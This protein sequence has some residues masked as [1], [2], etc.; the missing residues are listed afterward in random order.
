MVDYEEKHIFWRL[1]KLLRERIAM[2]YTINH[3]N[4]DWLQA[5][6]TSS[7]QLTKS[8][9]YNSV[10]IPIE[11]A[12]NSIISVFMRIHR[13]F[14]SEKTAWVSLSREVI[15]LRYLIFGDRYLEGDETE[16]TARP[17]VWLLLIALGPI[18]SSVTE[19]QLYILVACSFSLKFFDGTAN[20]PSL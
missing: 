11:K 1:L 17:W 16:G 2:S 8:Y 19:Q 18:A 20:I 5:G 12:A 15:A 6:I 13:T 3:F 4:F 10:V 14:E 7:W 9:W